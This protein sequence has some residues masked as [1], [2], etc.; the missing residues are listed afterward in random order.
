MPLQA[1]FLAPLWK[2]SDHS[3]PGWQACP[4]AGGV[5]GQAFPGLSPATRS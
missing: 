5:S 3:H 4:A 2:Q 1:P